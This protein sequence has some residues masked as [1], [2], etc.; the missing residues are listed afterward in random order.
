MKSKRRVYD[1]TKNYKSS[2]R[3]FEE[4]KKIRRKVAVEY[5]MSRRRVV[6]DHK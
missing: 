5:K 4:Y 6:K 3:V 1:T 2:W